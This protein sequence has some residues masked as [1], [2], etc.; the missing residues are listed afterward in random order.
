[1]FAVITDDNIY[2][3]RYFTKLEDA[4]SFM[5]ENYA[6]EIRLA[7]SFGVEIVYSECDDRHFYILERDDHT[8]TADGARYRGFRAMTLMECRIE[9]YCLE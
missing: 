6:G 5:R 1:M 7:E 4:V 8:D 2:E 9:E 3:T